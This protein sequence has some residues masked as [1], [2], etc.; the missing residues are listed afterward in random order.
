MIK[1]ITTATEVKTGDWVQHKRTGELFQVGISIPGGF[2]LKFNGKL[3]YP[4]IPLA[5]KATLINDFNA[6]LL[7]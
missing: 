6:V 7:P 2:Q 5:S 4:P 3:G 1:E